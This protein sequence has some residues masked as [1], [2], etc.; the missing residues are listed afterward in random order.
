MNTALSTQNACTPPAIAK[1]PTFRIPVGDIGEFATLPEARRVEVQFKL[2]LLER[3]HALRGPGSFCKAAATIAAQARHQ[4]RGASQGTL[5]RAYYRYM[6]SGGDWR[7]QVAGYHGPSKQ[8]EDFKQEIRRRCE[9]NHRSVQEALRQLRQA[10]ADGASIP[11]YGTWIE[12]Y[13][14]QYPERP[15]PKAF[16]RGFYPQGWSL[17]NLRHYGPSKATRT[18][19]Q[20]GIAAAKAHFP[21][22]KRDP[23]KLR[24]MEVVVI[25]DFVLD[26][27]CVWPGDKSFP[28]QIAPVAGLMAM[29]VGTR[30]KLIWGLG[31]QLEREE[32]QPDG[33]IKKVR[34]GIRRVDVQ[35]LLHDLFAK[36]GLPEYTVTILCENATASIAPE[37]ELALGTLF[38][39]RVKIER[40]GLIDNRCL[41]NGFIERGGKPWEKGWIE[42]AF[43]ALWN[44]MGAMPGYKGSNARLNGPADMEAKINYSKL[45]I[46]HGEKSLNL[47]PEEIIKLRLPFPS[48]EAVERA[49]A[50]AVATVDS[51]TDHK[52]I[53]FDHVTEFLLEEGGEPQPFTSLALLPPSAQ[54]QVQLVERNESPME[55][56]AR[57]A[58]ASHFQPIPLSVLALLLLTPKRVEF[59]NNAVGFTHDK[60]GYTYIDSESRCLAGY[61][62][63]TEFLAYF[64]QKAPELLHLAALDGSYVGTLTRLGGR[65]GAID[66]RDKEAL[67]VAGGQVAEL[68]NRAKEE[69]RSRHGD[70]DA[71]LALDRAHNA[72]IVQEYKA[73]TAGLSKAE[74]LA[75]AATKTETAQRLERETKKAIAKAS[76]LHDLA[77]M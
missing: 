40:T 42:S 9:L 6:G 44:V 67:S 23:S 70:A 51:R 1:A 75:A 71:Q 73:R 58:Q 5:I 21:S 46:G 16:P 18:L 15:I 31:P 17:R 48:P 36:F 8:P 13:A 60:V 64:D 28:A 22:V 52:Y 43:N 57:L 72:A 77:D 10:W 24:P 3:L 76:G 19:F 74:R 68:V 7:S 56:W 45:L 39:G 61:D 41:T 65:R 14:N 33:T 4:M 53:G 26:C 34:C 49:F 25:D 2:G 30:Y 35:V 62:E 66:I 12:Y 59:K 32:K 20:R 11:G 55:R 29:C 27:N 47:P 38:E 54:M 50:W 69:I 63:G 37:L